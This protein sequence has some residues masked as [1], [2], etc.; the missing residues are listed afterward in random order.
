MR[1]ITA[2]AA[3]A[4]LTM[5]FVPLAAQADDGTAAPAGPPM[6]W[7]SRSLGCSVSEASVRQ[8]AD[9]L[10]PLAPLGYRYVIL[11][12]CW[13]AA[14]R[15]SGALTPDP[16]RFPGGVKALAD[17][18]HG[19]GLKLGL[20]LSAGTKSCAGGG[21]GSYGTEAADA[22][23]VKNWGA[24]YV[25]YDW[26]SV[27]TADFPGQNVQQIAQILY[28]R[29]RQALGGSIAFAMNNEDGSTVPWLWGKDA[30]ATTWRTNVYNKPITDGYAAMVG[31]WETNQLRQQY[32]GPGSW[33][34]P[35]L[36]QAGGTGMTEAEYRTQVSL[37]AVGASPLILQ[38][39]P[40][41]A[42]AAIV[43]DPEVVAVDQDKLGIPGRLVSSD[44][45][46]HVLSKPLDG[47]DQAIVLFN[48]SDRAATITTE[49]APSRYRVEDLWTGAVSTTRSVVAAQVPAHAAVM[50]RVGESKEK[51][52]PSVL[53]ESDPAAFLGDD[54]PSVLEPGK[55]RE[56]V[57]RVT[58]SGGTDRLK[59]VQVALAVPAGW[60]ATA[61]TP[62]GTGR[63]DAGETF[64]VKWAVT[65]P[66]D[67]QLKDYEITAT[68]ANGRSTAVVKVAQAPG[69]GTTYLSDLTP[70]K[71][72]SYFGPVEKDTSN[73]DKA[74]GDGRPITI[75]GVVYPKGLGAH[76]PADI[77]FYT[78]GTCSA[79]EFQAGIDDEVGN[80]GSAVFE[81]WADGG[82][83][84]NSGLVTGA[85]PAR[86]VTAS[87]AGANFVRLVATNGGDNATSDH[88]D[89]AGASITCN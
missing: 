52:Q 44:G 18:V 69:R 8:A 67:A 47:G 82:R 63:L 55:Q 77:E 14:Q 2:A 88:A 40:A 45:W 33:T 73:G 54:H 21:P 61:R 60:E 59:D 43:A 37:W 9:A 71:A 35:D 80:A 49:L 75:G 50:Y 74:A 86:K 70:T 58:N 28:P 76:A 16:T 89:F 81:V 68:A 65:P 23:Q 4:L 57:T 36:I 25:K 24:D 13:L 51:A 10:V 26:C 6:G 38:A 62:A 66:A 12:G 22:Q 53:V 11:D 79:V 46:Y 78:A 85:Q 19:K 31:I 56:V 32:A 83:V 41:K 42:P 5:P 48:E 72:T 84:A 15:A 87:V 29:M 34:D 30:G 3:A 27:P 7:S 39:D 17:Y 1:A 20:S 64:T